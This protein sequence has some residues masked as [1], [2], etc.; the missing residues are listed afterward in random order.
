MSEQEPLKV[1]VHRALGYNPEIEGGDHN[2]PDY[3]NDAAF[4]LRVIFANRIHICPP[5][6]GMGWEALRWGQDGE[7][8]G[9][10]AYGETP[11]EAVC[12]WLV[13]Y[14]ATGGRVE[15]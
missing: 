8:E 10:P 14:H 12:R 2:I 11:E 9:R 1:Q 4:V 13:A 5:F 3:E 15:V 7:D 6:D